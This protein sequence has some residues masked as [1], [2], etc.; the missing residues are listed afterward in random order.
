[1]T[2]IREVKDGQLQEVVVLQDVEKAQAHLTKKKRKLYDIKQDVSTKKRD[3]YEHVYR[4][5]KE[6]TP[7]PGRRERERRGGIE[8]CLRC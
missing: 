8:K 4:E 6:K 2:R 3:L 5:Q 1:M 7:K